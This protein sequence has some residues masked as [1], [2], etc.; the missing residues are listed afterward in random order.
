[1]YCRQS[2]SPTRPSVVKASRVGLTVVRIR[3]EGQWRAI[4]WVSLGLA[5]IAAQDRRCRKHLIH[6][7]SATNLVIHETSRDCRTS[8]SRKVR[9]AE[10]RSTAAE[11]IRSGRRGPVSR[12]ENAKD[13]KLTRHARNLPP[14]PA[15]FRTGA[16]DRTEPGARS[17][18]TTKVPCGG[19]EPGSGESPS[20]KMTSDSRAH[21][22]PHCADSWPWPA[23]KPLDENASYTP[24]AGGGR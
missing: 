21:G 12:R 8:K 13:G 20:G 11:R 7:R 15:Q 14:C 18:G 22:R 9:I 10:G 3:A 5:A 23:S 2:A 16:A 6:T 19:T 17:G 1:M 24:P 4:R